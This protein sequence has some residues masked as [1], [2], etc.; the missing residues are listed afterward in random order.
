MKDG[1]DGNENGREIKCLN[2]TNPLNEQENQ[3]TALNVFMKLAI[4]TELG[5]KYQPTYGVARAVTAARTQKS[6]GKG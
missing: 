1:W 6:R 3:I 2:F 5:R 4:N